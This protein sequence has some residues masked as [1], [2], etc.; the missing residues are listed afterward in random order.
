[1]RSTSIR[2]AT[3]PFA[4]RMRLTSLLSHALTR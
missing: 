1:M 2:K 3:C 4:I